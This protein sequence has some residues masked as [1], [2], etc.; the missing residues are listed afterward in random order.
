[1]AKRKITGHN[2]MAKRKTKKRTEEYTMIYKKLHRKLKIE[3]NKDMWS[4]D[5]WVFFS[6]SNS[7]KV[8]FLLW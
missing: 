1:M 5:Y 2:T 4:K 7:N 6:Q 8:M 3:W